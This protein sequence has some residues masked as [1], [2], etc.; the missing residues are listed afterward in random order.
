MFYVVK[1]IE[2]SPDEIGIEITKTPPSCTE[3]VLTE[4]LHRCFVRGDLHVS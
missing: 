2:D 4:P 3:H 1:V